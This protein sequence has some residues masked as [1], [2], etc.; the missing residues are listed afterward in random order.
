MAKEYTITFSENIDYTTTFVAES[1]AEALS[2]VSQGLWDSW[3][4]TILNSQVDEDSIEI[5][6]VTEVEL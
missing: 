5:Q 2:M 4:T 3:E 6:E 1:E